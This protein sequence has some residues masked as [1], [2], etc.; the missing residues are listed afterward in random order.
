VSQPPPRAA[1]ARQRPSA[2]GSSSA[3]SVRRPG[4]PDRDHAWELATGAAGSPSDASCTRSILQ[5]LPAP[6]A[7]QLPT[8]WAGCGYRTRGGIVAGTLFVLPRSRS[9][10]RC[11]DATCAGHVPAIARRALGREAGVVANRPARR[12]SHRQAARCAIRCCGDRP[13]RRFVALEGFDVSRSRRSSRRGARRCRTAARRNHVRSPEASTTSSGDG[14]HARA[15]IDDDT[16]DAAARALVC[17]RFVAVV[18]VFVAIWGAAFVRS[19]RRSARTGRWPPW[20]GIFN[21]A[22]LVTFGGRLRWCSRKFVSAR[23]YRRKAGFHA[24]QI[25]DGRSRSG[26]TT[27]GPLIMVSRSSVRRRMTQRR[28]D[29]RAGRSRRCGARVAIRSSRSCRRS[30]SSSPAG[31]SRGIARQRPCD[32]SAHSESRRRGR[33]RRGEPGRVFGVHVFWP[34]GFAPAQPRT[35]L[36]RRLVDSLAERPPAALVSRLFRAGVA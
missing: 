2:S 31:R 36:G 25:S 1:D 23:R 30:C 17:R 18:A 4:R 21:K 8:Y 16:P 28:S 34:G 24:S 15:V 12:L 3:S 7:T 33:R 19:S 14:A 22:A 10:R 11:V 13:S 5:L 26:E 9:S 27:P 29:R 20:D 6:E 32:R 35:G